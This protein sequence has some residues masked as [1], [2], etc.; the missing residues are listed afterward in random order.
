[1]G[2]LAHGAIINDT[3]LRDGEQSAGV[4]FST[5][6]KIAIA[7]ELDAIGVPELEIGIPAMGPEERETI[8]A[9]TGLG[10][11]ASLMVWCRMRQDDLETARGLN[12]NLID[13]SIPVSDQQIARKLERTR[14]WVLQQIAALVPRAR[15]LGFRVCVGGEDSSRADPEFLRRV[16]NAA[17]EAGAERFRFADTVGITDPFTV[18]ERIRDLRVASSLDIEIHA[19]DDLGLATANSLAAV[20][21]GASHINTTVLGLGERAGN[22]PLEE[23]VVGLQKIHGIDSGVDLRNYR[24]VSQMVETASG[25]RISP[26]KSLVGERVFSHESGIHVDGILKDPIN[27]QG[28][29]PA[30]FGR[31]HAFVLGKHSGT[32]GLMHAYAELG[33][34]LE[35]DAARRILPIV[36]RF[37][38]TTKRSPSPGELAS[39]HQTHAVLGA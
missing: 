21:G 26:F 39:F 32:R 22:A 3:T 31:H 37:V 23:I 18:F 19:H 7:T 33:I 13:L 10:L 34:V 11:T 14:D 30:A 25:C 5:G 24:T 38:E 17:E 29:D 9:L 27:Y 6:E 28:V 16:L 4:A 36:R 35:R 8:A 2:S 20:R 1:M 15:D 12:A